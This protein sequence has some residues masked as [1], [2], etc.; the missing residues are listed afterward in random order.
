MPFAETLEFAVDE[1]AGNH[2]KIP[3]RRRLKKPVVYIA[4]IEKVHVYYY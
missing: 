4:T 1:Y 3:P 2:G